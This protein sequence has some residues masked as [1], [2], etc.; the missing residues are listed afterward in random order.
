MLN[1]FYILVVVQT[2]LIQI[3]LSEENFVAVID[4]D[5]KG[6]SSSDA[7]ALTDRLR[8]EVIKFTDNIVVER[9]KIDE[10]LNE[11]GFQLSGCTSSECMVEVGKLLGANQIIGGSISNIGNTFSVNARIIDVETGEI[12]NSISYDF[13]GF[14]DELLIN[15]MRNVVQL[16]FSDAVADVIEVG[17]DFEYYDNGNIKSEGRSINKIKYGR[18]IYYYE[19]GHICKI[20]NYDNLMTGKWIYYFENGKTKKTGE[21]VEGFPSGKWFF[22]NVNDTL[23]QC[24]EFIYNDSKLYRIKEYYGNGNL[25]ATNEVDENNVVWTRVVYKIDGSVI[26]KVKYRY[27]NGVFIDFYD[28][29]SKKC[30]GVCK[31]FNF[32]FENGQIFREKLNWKEWDDKGNIIHN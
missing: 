10:I 2:L 14:I 20:G 26:K 11:Q 25:K 8:N 9:G 19:D 28:N 3:V 16:L 18:W 5:G 1:K 30:F 13:I 15:G 23:H 24:F 4:F 6:I 17:K 22:Y 21:F 7:S 31:G 29:G 27:G 32:S 12:I